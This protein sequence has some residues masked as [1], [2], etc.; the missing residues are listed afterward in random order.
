MQ[1]S[2]AA[3]TEVMLSSPLHLI[4]SLANRESFISFAEELPAEELFPVSSLEAAA[5]AV[6]SNSPTA[7]QYGEPQGFLPLREWLSEDW[8]RTKRIDVG[9]DQILLTTGVQQAMDLLARVYVE[10]GDRVLVE[11]PASPGYL[12]VF[13]MQGAVVIPVDSDQNGLIPERL[14]EQIERTQPKLLVASPNFSNPTGVLWSL[15]RR[16]EVLDLCR[17]HNILIIEDNSYGDLH[18][19]KLS[20]REFTSL[21]P[22]LFALDGSGS[23]QGVLYI[24]SFSKTIAPALRT[25]WAAGSR[26]LIDMLAAAK[27]LA[28]WQ[29]STLNQ[30]F[31]HNMLESSAFDIHE[32]IKML[33]R[34]YDTRLKLMN[35]LL[36]RPAW[37]DAS[38]VIPKGGMFIWLQLPDGLD[39][40]ALLK[41]AL[42]KGA[43]FLPGK[44]CYPD[45]RGSG[46]IRLNFT[47][48][49]RDELLLGMSLIG[50]AI[51]E[52][53]ARS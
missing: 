42:G 24:G 9:P 1:Y 15:E 45:G 43:A 6:I 31:L 40:L 32:H 19:E 18:F 30:R 2:F 12:Q 28:D 52:F 36:Q 47:H 33:N 21:Y 51:G 5:A 39:S 20:Q 26:P 27:Q 25:G 41:C 35:G 49:G 37:Q 3:R 17:E 46:W 23:G 53:T 16:K 22:S 29:S 48:P 44:L 4:R 7:L 14:L 11:S 10:P 50:E 38:Y 8:K 13:K 34:E